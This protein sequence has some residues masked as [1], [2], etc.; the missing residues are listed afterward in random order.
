M[1]YFRL[2]GCL[3]ALLFILPSTTATCPSEC[4]CTQND[5]FVN[6]SGRGLTAL[7]E[8]I[9][10]NVIS[11]NISHNSIKDLDNSLTRFI[12]MRILD[13]S[14]NQLS[15][16]PTHLPVALWEIH[17]ASNSIKILVKNDI[18]TQWN[19]KKLDVSNNMIERTFF[20]KNTLTR[21]NFLNFSGNRFSTVPTNMPNNLNTLDLSHNNLFQ[22]LPGTFPQAG[23]SKLYLNNNDFKFIPNGTFNELTGLQLM[24]LNTNPWACNSKQDIFYLLTWVR[25][26]TAT[27]HGCPCTEETT[28]SHKRT[29]TS[30]P[31]TI[32]L[33]SHISAHRHQN[34]KSTFHTSA[35]QETGTSPLSQLVTNTSL[36]SPPQSSFR[37]PATQITRNISNQTMSSAESSSNMPS[38]TAKTTKRPSSTMSI[39]APELTSDI[40]VST[41]STAMV[42]SSNATMNSQTNGSVSLS[43]FEPSIV[44][45]TTSHVAMR[46]ISSTIQTASINLTTGTTN[47]MDQNVT[48]Q[49]TTSKAHV[50]TGIT[51]DLM[52]LTMLAPLVV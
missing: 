2:S 37:K 35:S 36:N 14:S 47:S 16:M 13:I 23:L 41:K 18:A 7:P 30:N 10:V 52:I 45:A 22:I 24:T 50:C 20:V 6:C 26:T 8:S 5:R 42:N 33:P 32:T 44:N 1:G 38:V 34:E 3:L 19:L 25:E 39:T 46:S 43:T 12:N 40:I 28:C 4:S 21:L 29:S 9:Q 11:L 31:S 15:N 49:G 27:V 51:L 17:A 48:V